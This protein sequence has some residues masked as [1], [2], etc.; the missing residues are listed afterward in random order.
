MTTILAVIL[1]KNLNQSPRWVHCSDTQVTVFL[2]MKVLETILS[3]QTLWHVFTSKGISCRLHIRPILIQN[4]NNTK[5]TVRNFGTALFGQQI[6]SSNKSD[7]WQHVF[8]MS[9]SLTSK[10]STTM[11]LHMLIELTKLLYASEL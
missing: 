10:L 6:C 2:Q 11:P 1:Q 3:L 4:F 8:Q 9:V 7:T 5:Y